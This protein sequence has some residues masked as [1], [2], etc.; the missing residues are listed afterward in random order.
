[1]GLRTPSAVLRTGAAD[2]Q[3]GKAA[4]PPP[5]VP[6]SMRGS[7][8]AQPPQH[9]ILISCISP[10]PGVLGERGLVCPARPPPSTLYHVLDV[11]H[12][13]EHMLYNAQYVQYDTSCI[14]YV[15][16]YI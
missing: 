1:M 4:F 16:H 11:L 9:D 12:N 13:F 7:G 8:G 15:I 10:G 3:R 6:L 14:S 5:C 2:L